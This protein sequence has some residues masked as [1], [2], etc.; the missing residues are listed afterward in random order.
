MHGGLTSSN[1]FIQHRVKCIHL[2]IN[3]VYSVTDNDYFFPLPKH[4]GRIVHDLCLIDFVFQWSCLVLSLK[5]KQSGVVKTLRRFSKT[6]E[7]LSLLF[8]LFLLDTKF[9]CVADGK[10]EREKMKTCAEPASSTGF[11]SHRGIQSK[12]FWIQP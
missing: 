12:G 9:M 1:I 8:E 2:S 4:L 11:S 3:H 7:N 6:I 5:E 10:L